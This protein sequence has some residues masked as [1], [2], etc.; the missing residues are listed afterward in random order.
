VVIAFA[1]TFKQNSLNERFFSPKKWS[2]IK[3]ELCVPHQLGL[4]LSIFS[5]ILISSFSG[6]PFIFVFKS[7]KSIELK[8]PSV[9]IWW[10]PKICV[11]ND[12]F[13]DRAFVE[14]TTLD[15]PM[16]DTQKFKS[17][18]FDMSKGLLL[19]SVGQRNCTRRTC[20]CGA[21]LKLSSCVS[22]RLSLVA[23]PR[24]QRLLSAPTSGGFVEKTNTTLSLESLF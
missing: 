6:T 3:L 23:G 9:W 13:R 17:N 15:L 24:Y 8:A 14:A 12:S 4:H 21:K 11:F 7:S 2:L 1:N 22:F 5:N 19:K 16:L 20:R 18:I 10:L